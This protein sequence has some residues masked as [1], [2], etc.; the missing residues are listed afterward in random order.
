MGLGLYRL[1]TQ[2]KSFFEKSFFL[3][4][5][6]TPLYAKKNPF[7]SFKKGWKIVTVIAVI[8]RKKS[9]FFVWILKIFWFQLNQDFSVSGDSASI[10]P[11]ESPSNS[12]RP[13]SPDYSCRSQLQSIE[14]LLLSDKLF[15]LLLRQIILTERLFRSVKRN[16]GI[17]F[18]FNL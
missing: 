12:Q 10:Q 13:L 1:Y 3:L 15:W 16:N 4:F 5:A 6:Y 18:Y 7:F 9:F 2:K 11:R 17:S 8:P 14:L